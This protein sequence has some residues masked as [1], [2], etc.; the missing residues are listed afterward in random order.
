MNPYETLDVPKDA[1]QPTI[2]RAYEITGLEALIK[3]CERE[4]SLGNVM[5]Q[6]LAG[7]SYTVDKVEEPCF[8]NNYGNI[9]S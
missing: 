8:K 3:N 2:K 9:R 4:I 1:D 6:L 7:Y 5:L